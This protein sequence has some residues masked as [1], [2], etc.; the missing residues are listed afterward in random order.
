M[1]AAFLF[2]VALATPAEEIAYTTT[3]DGY[4][5]GFSHY[6]NPGKP[7]VVLVHGISC[8]HRFYDL[9]PEQSLALS[10]WDAGFDVWNL[11]LR[12]HGLSLKGKKGRQRPSSVDVYGEQDLPAAFAYVQ[13]RTG[14]E[15]LHYV[16]HSMGGMVLAIYLA[17]HPEPPLASAVVLASPLDLRDPDPLIGAV[18]HNTWVGT[19]LPSLPTPFGAKLVGRLGTKSPLQIDQLLYNPEL[20]ERGVQQRSMRQIVAPVWR[21]ES[22]QFGLAKDGDFRSADGTDIYRERLS[23]IKVPMLFIAGRADRI[24]HPDRVLAYYEAVGSADKEWIVASRANGFAG[25]YG[26]L[27]YALATAAKTE[28]F[29]RVIEWLQNHP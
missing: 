21:G 5:L 29:P 14:A 18:L 9:E 13:Q 11:D 28:I 27:D 4:E 15:K 26:H 23:E 10:L 2:Q 8:N 6:D 12:G 24:V 22:R 3:E 7:P 17:T 20:M 19:I 1:I 16:G 25:D